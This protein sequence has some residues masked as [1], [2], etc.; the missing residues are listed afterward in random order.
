MK[1]GR[2]WE[3]KED[4]WMRRRK[5]KDGEEREWRGRREGGYPG[6]WALA[7]SAFISSK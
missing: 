3:E 2:E 5:G 6:I 4:G 1:G 7:Q